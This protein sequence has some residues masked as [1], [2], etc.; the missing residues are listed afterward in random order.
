MDNHSLGNKCFQVLQTISNKKPD[1]KYLIELWYWTKF[2]FGCGIDKLV[3]ELEGEPLGWCCDWRQEKYTQMIDDV[4]K[5]QKS[6][7]PNESLPEISIPEEIVSP[8]ESLP[9]ISIPEETVSP[10]ESLPEISIPEE[11]D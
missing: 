4:L 11:R 3:R 8:N 10:N 7:S 2:I 5:L 6:V 1:R 9:E